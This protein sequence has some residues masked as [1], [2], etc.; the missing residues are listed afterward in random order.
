MEAIAL[1]GAREVFRK[2]VATPRGDLR[3]HHCRRG[4]SRP[5]DRRRK[6]RRAGQC[7]SLRTSGVLA[8]RRAT[9][10]T[11][12]PVWAIALLLTVV[13]V[14]AG[15]DRPQPVEIT[16][17]D[18][19]LLVLG[20]AILP[21]VAGFIYIRHCGSTLPEAVIV[22]ATIPIA[23]IIGVGIAYAVLQAGWMT[24]AGFVIATTMFAL[25]PAALF[26]G[27]G[28]WTARRYERKHT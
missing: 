10:T 9:L 7:A 20:A 19:A 24:L 23:E 11:L 16:L 27:V 4:R 25:V 2:R 17:L 18:N 8:M 26:G 21:F 28:G 14:L 12:S 22:G 15:H 6:R 1:D 3:R 13:H 5:R